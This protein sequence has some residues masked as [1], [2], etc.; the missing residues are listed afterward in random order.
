MLR[1]ERE[2]AGQIHCPIAPQRLWDGVDEIE[3]DIAEPGGAQRRDRLIDLTGTMGAMHPLEHRRLE[4][5]GAE[6]NPV[7]SGGS[8]RRG[9]R[10]V[11]IVR[12]GF[13]GYFCAGGEGAIA[14]ERDQQPRDG[15]GREPRGR[16]PTEIDRVKG[17]CELPGRMRLPAGPLALDGVNERCRR[18]FPTYRNGKVAVAAPPGAEGDVDV[19]VHARKYG[20]TGNPGSRGSGSR[21]F[22]NTVMPGCPDTRIPG[23]PDPRIPGS[24]EQRRSHEPIEPS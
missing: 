17:R 4:G 13:E 8:P 10:S 22:P 11:H 2:R 19:E 9:P 23:Y 12:I 16:A 20:G 14:A 1:R 18:R 3:G 7:D 15:L 24:T 5:L 6:G 21:E